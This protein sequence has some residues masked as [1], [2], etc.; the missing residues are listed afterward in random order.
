MWQGIR[1]SDKGDVKCK[2]DCINDGLG[3]VYLPCFCIPIS[4]ANGNDFNVDEK[5]SNIC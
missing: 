4:C 2:E 5:A 1:N 3:D